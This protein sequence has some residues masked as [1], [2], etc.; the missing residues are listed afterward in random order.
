VPRPTALLADDEPALRDFLRRE[1]AAVWPELRVVGEAGDGAQA[2]RLAGELE[3][4]VLFLD[5]RM[6]VLGGLEVAGRLSGPRHVV[7]VTAYDEYAVKAFESAAA[8]YLVKPVSRARLERTVERLRGRLAQAAPDLPRLLEAV[9]AE[10]R[11]EPRHLAWLQCSVRDEIELV[12]VE[13]VDLFQ[14]ADKYTVVLGR[15]GEWVIRTP[16]KDL[17]T[18]LD[19]ARFWRVHRNA[20]VR[21]AAVARVRRDFGGH[22]E[23]H[24]HGR[25][26]PVPVGRSYAHRFK[27]M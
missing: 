5:I 8:D 6:P 10:L 17:E 9:R 26:Q 20:I 3:P 13:D 22:V 27:Q 16:L 2:L 24:L 21:L 12:A 25:E 4:D 15:R 18:Q 19:P 23:L 1:L 7:F 11:P 14:A